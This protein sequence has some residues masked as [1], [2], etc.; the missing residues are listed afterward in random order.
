MKEKKY[1]Y[2]H[3]QRQLDDINFYDIHHIQTLHLYKKKK[4]DS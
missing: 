2:E 1:G 3:N 4:N